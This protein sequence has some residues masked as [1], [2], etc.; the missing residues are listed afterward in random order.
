MHLRHLGIT[1]LLL[2]LAAVAAAA[3]STPELLP[4]PRQITMQG[5]A[6]ILNRRVTI[7]VESK[8][9][10]DRSAAQ[11][12]AQELSR[13]DHL[14]VRI[15]QGHSGEILLVR[16]QS[17]RGEQLLQRAGVSLPPAAQTEGYVLLVS[18][19][20]AVVIAASAAGILYGVETL[21][22]LFHPLADAAVADATQIVD[23]PALR[24]RGVQMDLSRG[25]IP[26]LAAF[27][28]DIPLL[29][30]FK[31]NALVLYFENTFAYSNLPVWAVPGG[32]I[33][34]EEATEIVSLAAKYHITVIP[35]QEAFGHLHLG[36][37]EERFQNL[38]EKPY[39]GLLSPAVPASLD[40]ISK[41]YAELAQYFPGPFFHIG[42]DETIA[43][44]TGRSQAMQKAE[45][46]GALYLNYIKAIAQR[47]EPYH[48]KILFWGDIAQNH[49]ELL[50]QLPKDMIAVPWNYAPRQSF[51]KLI[52]PFTD[53]GLETWVAPG[54]SNWSRIFPDYNEATPN[55]V[56]FVRDGR[57]LGATG[58]LNTNWNDDGESMFDY[59]WYGIALGAAQGWEEQ[60]SVPRFQGAYDWALYR[61][62]G[63]FFLKQIETLTQIHALLEKTIHADGSDRLMWHQAFSPEGQRIYGEMA[64]AAH[65]VRLLA[66]DVIASMAAHR[67]GARRYPKL[68]MPVEF[69]AR[70]F[71]FVGEKAI[72]A[73]LIAQLYKQAG[74]PGQAPYKVNRIFNRIN[75]INGLVQDMRDGVTTL[76][77]EY[78]AL[79]LEGNT[80]YFVGNILVRYDNERMYWEQQS[81]R[82]TRVQRA[83]NTEGTLP[84]LVSDPVAQ[85]RP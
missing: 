44:G 79:W 31:I 24:W 76:R 65:P 8:N 37:R 77:G 84:P 68:L 25:A 70:R 81:R 21:R 2:C 17:K 50:S 54:V 12:L 38:L 27:R 59:C 51:V 26:S 83:Y 43:L 22:Q 63:H 57:A 69:A 73:V 18:P 16:A 7:G 20:Q 53:A 66:E 47:L 28:R 67:D 45:G 40:F 42:A 62:D 46:A 52:Q 32:A 6:L 36:L 34:P 74:K 58:I 41:M 75:S 80:P 39:G 13:I 78:R 56:N 71:D 55:I 10:Q 5:G 30:E 82:F 19:K 49:P 23:W 1:I 33:T 60:P 14:P 11:V 35:E 9:A 15:K 29:A 64:P 85:Q 72:Y 48:R 3:P 4:Y 61:A